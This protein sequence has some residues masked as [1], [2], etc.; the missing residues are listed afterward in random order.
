[1]H[2]T[3]LPL[4]AERQIAALGGDGNNDIAPVQS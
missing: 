3:V 1:L 2:P 4:L